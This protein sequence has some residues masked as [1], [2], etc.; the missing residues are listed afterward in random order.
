MSYLV[1]QGRRELG[2][3]IALGATPSAIARL[4]VGHGMAVALAA[5]GVGLGGALVGGRLLSSMLFGVTA[6]DP[7][8]ITAV[9]LGAGA[10]ALLA[11]W[12]PARRAGRVDS[13]VSLRSE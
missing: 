4:V 6:R 1:A 9:A 12:L 2:I 3:R 7:V 11:T 8:T 10:V 5:L 13:T